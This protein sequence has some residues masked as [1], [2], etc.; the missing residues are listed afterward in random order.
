MLDE[1]MQNLRATSCRFTRG[2]FSCTICRMH[3]DTPCM[4]SRST[5]C[6]VQARYEQ[7]IRGLDV[8]GSF[9]ARFT[10]WMSFLNQ[11]KSYVIVRRHY[12]GGPRSV[13]HLSTLT[14][15][16]HLQELDLL[17]VAFWHG[18]MAGIA[19][20]ALPASSYFRTMQKNHFQNHYKSFSFFFIVTTVLPQLSR[21]HIIHICWGTS[22]C[23]Q[24]IFN[25]LGSL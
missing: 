24:S 25:T 10:V 1:S 7:A 4:K 20:R 14:R 15:L 3:G 9:N 18:S 19:P 17:N 6:S 21:A 16:F 5:Q 11:F 2:V 8:P 22:L 13:H 23:F 12:P